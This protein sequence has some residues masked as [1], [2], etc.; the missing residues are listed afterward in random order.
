MTAIL[1]SLKDENESIVQEAQT[2]AEKRAKFLNDFGNDIL[3]LERAI[4][5][6]RNWLVKAG[7]DTG[8]Q[9]LD[10]NFSGDKH[11][12]QG[13]FAALRNAG[14][15]PSSRPKD[16]KLV[17]F[18]CWWDKDGAPFDKKNQMRLW[19]NFTS[20]SC[21][22]VKVGTKMVEQDVYDIVCE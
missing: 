22:R 11:T 1:K 14:Y 10:L 2:R 20:T 15:I 5:P 17:D 6:V 19:I 8:N 13:I 4:E 3:D 9:C 21:K 7:I 16:E 12:L 18:S